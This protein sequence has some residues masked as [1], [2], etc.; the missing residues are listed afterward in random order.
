APLADTDVDRKRQARIDDRANR[1]EEPLLVVA[2]RLRR[3]GD[4]DDPSAVPVDVALQERH[5][6]IPRGFLDRPRE[7][8]ERLGRGRRSLGRNY[9]V[10]ARVPDEGYRRVPMLA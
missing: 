8:V 3:S 6:V 5:L 1:T 2:K 7:N 4:E 10:E 9:L